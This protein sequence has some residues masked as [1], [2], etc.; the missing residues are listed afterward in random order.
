MYSHWYVLMFK[1]FRDEFKFCM[2]NQVGHMLVLFAMHIYWTIFMVKVG[3][4]IFSSGRYKNVYDNRESKLDNNT[5]K[6]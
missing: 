4:G 3:L 2:I 1:I 6:E 5:K